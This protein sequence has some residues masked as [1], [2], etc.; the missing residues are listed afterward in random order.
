M[1]KPLLITIVCFFLAA[2]IGL[3]IYNFCTND[4]FW[5]VSAANCL[6]L[7]IVIGVSFFIVQKQTDSRIRKERFIQL[8]DSL[9]ILVENENSY[10][11]SES[12]PVEE[13]R[14]RCR[15]MNN[16]ISLM[17]QYSNH[18]SVKAEVNNIRSL[19]QEYEHVIDD[20]INDMSTLKKLHSELRRPLDLISQNLFTISLKLYK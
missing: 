2:I 11:I 6:S 12:K 19:Y 7:I 13:I 15:T 9:L 17:E 18:F 5:N 14:M 3:A 8:A 10:L 20:H 4:D 1:S 16:K